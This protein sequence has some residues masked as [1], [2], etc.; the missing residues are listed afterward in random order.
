MHKFR[1]SRGIRTVSSEEY[2]IYY[3]DDFIGELH[4]HY[5]K[6]NE[7]E[8]CH[9]IITKDIENSIIEELVEVV[10]D[11]IISNPEGF[12]WIEVYSATRLFGYINEPH[13]DSIKAKQH[14]LTKVLNTFQV[15]K[16]QLSEAAATEYFA[17]LH[18][19]VKQASHFYDQEYKIDL[20]G[21]ND[22]EILYIQVKLGMIGEKEITKVVTK[23][24]EIPDIEKIKFAVFVA[25]RFPT[26]SELLRKK[27]E[28]NLNVKVMY[29][30]KY[31]VLESSAKFRRTLS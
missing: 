4:I 27:L 23:V 18:Y 12:F 9:L 2:T 20:I 19:D 11:N 7:D 5:M 31:Q 8:I 14:D 1:F 24:A 3:L 15:A 22:E 6:N 16:G 29:V 26:N 28:N 21:E 30:H 25:E 17:K 10:I 13:P